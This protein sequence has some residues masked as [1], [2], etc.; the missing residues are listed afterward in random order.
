MI[1]ECGRSIVQTIRHWA[2]TAKSR[3][4]SEFLHFSPA[5]E[6]HNILSSVPETCDNPDQAAHYH[7]L[8]HFFHVFI[9]RPFLSYFPYFE[10]NNSR[11]MRSPCFLC[12]CVSLPLTFEW[13][14]QSLWNLVCISCHLSPSQRYFITPSH[15]SVRLYAYPPFV[16][17]QRLGKN[18]TAATN[19]HAKINE[20][21]DA[22]FSMRSVSYQR[23]VGDSFFPEFLSFVPFHSIPSFPH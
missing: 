9:L 11:L 8:D 18:V 15:Q 12:L 14:N 4:N 23:R 1:H 2:M 3:F 22:S 10:K 6:H 20:L 13:L 21:L 17:R 16:A 19:T 7:N 5:N